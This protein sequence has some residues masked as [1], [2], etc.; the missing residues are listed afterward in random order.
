M[1]ACVLALAVVL[2]GGPAAAHDR[3]TSYSTW[4][5]RGREARVTVRL[6]DLDVSRFPWAAGKGQSR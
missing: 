5:I 3:T 2:V 6:A 4:E 1:T